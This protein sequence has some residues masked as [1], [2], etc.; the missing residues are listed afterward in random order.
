M[1]NAE[2]DQGI[3]QDLNLLYQGGMITKV[4]DVSEKLIPVF[5]KSPFLWNIW[6]SSHR[7]I[8]KPDLAEKACRKATELDPNF[9]AAH[10]N[11]G[12]A[13]TLQGKT[14]EAHLAF[15]KALAIEPDLAV[16]HKNLGNIWRD[17]GE[18]TRATDAFRKAIT[19][20][21]HYTEAYICL[22]DTLKDRGN[23]DEAIT[24]YQHALAIDPNMA[25]PH[26]N[27]GVALKKQGKITAALAAYQ[28]A[29]RLNPNLPAVHNNIGLVLHDL[30]KSEQA[31]TYYLAALKLDPLA[32]DVHNHLG[33]VLSSL[34]K[35]EDAGDAFTKAIALNPLLTSA[36]RHLSLIR[37]YKPDS[38]HLK[39][40]EVVH[41]DP[42]LVDE[43]R[44]QICFALAKAYE[45]LGDMARSFYH[46]KQGNDIQKKLQVYEIESDR[47]LFAQIKASAASLD[48]AGGDMAATHST[49]TPI[50]ILGMPRSGTTLVEQIIS[51]HADVAAGGELNYTHKF[52]THLATGEVPANTANQLKFR[53][54]YLAEIK[55]IQ[56]EGKFVTDKMPHNFRYI[57]LIFNCLPE[58]KIVLTDRTPAAVCWSNYKRFF[59][60]AALG[61][62][63]DIK[64]TAIFYNLYADLV[65]FWAR[66]YP[67]QIYQVN[68]E[69]LTENPE[70]ETHRLIAG[71]GLPW[72]EA[73]LYPHLN[74]RT[75]Q[76][77]SQLQI[78]QPIY[79]NSSEDW[80][81]FEQFLGGAFDQLG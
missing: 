72:D 78:R 48:A 53:A 50:F 19:L 4:I 21:P 81:Q 23:F 26:N 70:S 67:R 8:G 10:N 65:R 64:T 80:R 29:L 3:M 25:E 37:K 41:Q 79:K 1:T 73:C 63:N 31:V 17:Q 33:N 77:A 36:H 49:V 59:R 28:E 38:P 7:K 51:A 22:G 52:G 27:I 54:E 75:V 43:S 45:D 6:G 47:K 14:G 30:G 55:K 44:S 40:M 9:A 68:Y 56:G 12:C 34:G 5:P 18:L 20:Q 46:I 62:G 42:N 39:Q 57:G 2:P 61:Y 11:L 76:T 74:Q 15:S 32:A 69:H 71:L 24:T 60:S 16:A 58:A 13:L 66:R 35:F